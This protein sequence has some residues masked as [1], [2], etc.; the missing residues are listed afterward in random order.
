VAPTPDEIAGTAVRARAEVEATA[1]RG[2][3]DVDARAVLAAAEADA[4]AI[5]D[6]AE[7]ELA[8]AR[9]AS[10]ADRAAA[11]L[12]LDEARRR[13]DEILAEA[14]DLRRRAEQ[15]TLDRLLATRAD[16]HDA[17][18]RLSDLAEPVIDLTDGGLERAAAGGPDLVPVGRVPEDALD[19]SSPASPAAAGEPAA[20]PVDSLVRS[21]IGRAVDSAS[22]PGRSPAFS[23]DRPARRRQQLRDGRNIL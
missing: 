20:D 1:I 12:L 22:A 6:R 3:A 18:E 9:R 17:I 23:T 2:L 15:Q 8:D 16:I 14:S 10:E 5:R 11:Q 21:A 19:G 4:N 7:S 13:A